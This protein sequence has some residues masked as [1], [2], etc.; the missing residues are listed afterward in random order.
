MKAPSPRLLP[1]TIVALA[2]LLVWKSSTLL[3]AA[4][5][6]APRPAPAMVA[7]AE[8]AGTEAAKEAPPPAAAKPEPPKPDEPPPIGESEKALLQD[9][10]E[11]RRDLDARAEAVATRETL[12]AAMEQK[13]T[14]RVGELKALQAR[15]EAMDSARHQAEDAG[16]Q[17]LVRLYEAMKPK[18]AAGIFNDLPTPVLVDLIGRMKDAK[19][20]AIMAAM[21]QDKARDVTAELA[22]TRTGQKH[23]NGS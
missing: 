18:D 1:A 22:R 10:R 15:L 11:R 3:H 7:P 12:A 20:A 16:W 8:A 4:F 17:G 5:T 2:T 13:L 6:N 21:N 23:G 19:A 9:L 14:D